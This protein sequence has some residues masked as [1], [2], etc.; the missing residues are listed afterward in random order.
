MVLGYCGYCMISADRMWIAVPRLVMRYGPWANL[1][2]HDRLIVANI[3]K[4]TSWYGGSALAL[5]AFDCGVV[6][7]MPVMAQLVVWQGY[8]AMFLTVAATVAII[9]WNLL[10]AN[11]IR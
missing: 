1:P 2:L 8:N 10:Q 6:F 9:L 3:P 11:R 7:G 5:M 4:R